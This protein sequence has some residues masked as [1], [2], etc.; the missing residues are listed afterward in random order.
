[1]SLR[2]QRITERIWL[3]AFGTSPKSGLRAGLQICSKRY[4]KFR[5]PSLEEI[6]YIQI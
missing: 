4:I 5:A 6:L 2:R 3:R 1:M